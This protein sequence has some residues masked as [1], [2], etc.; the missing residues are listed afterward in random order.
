MKILLIG[1]LVTEIIKYGIW[2][3]GIDGLHLKRRFLGGSLACGYIGL[4]LLGLV[5]E[6]TPIIA[7]NGV[8]VA[9]YVCMLEC[10]R[11]EKL[12]EILKAVFIIIC[13]GEV[14]GNIMQLVLKLGLETFRGIKTSYLANNFIIIAC[15]CTLYIVKRKVSLH[16]SEQANRFYDIMIYFA[17][18]LMGT[19]L[20]LTVSGINYISQY[21]PEKRLE[22]LIKLL[23][24]IS[25]ISIICFIVILLYIFRENKLIKNYLEND[26]LLIM[27]QKSLYDAV[28]AKNKATVDFS[29][30][31][32]G[33]LVCLNEL[34][35]KGD[36]E[37]VGAY[38]ENMTG[39]IELI[40][41]KVYSTENDVIDAVLNYFVAALDE[42]VRI[43]V[44][45]K[46]TGELS[47]EPVELCTITSNIFKNAAEALCKKGNRI[48]YLDVSVMKN[49]GYMMLRVS[50][51]IQESVPAL[52]KRTGLPDTSKEDK[53][54]HGIG[55]RNVK[56]TVEKR[57]GIFNIDIGQEEFAVAI[58][59]PLEI[60]END[61]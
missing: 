60:R 49:R 2:F 54:N 27:T 16:G 20:C 19:S 31:L 6:G 13:A 35:H 40:R 51:S 8:A 12:L 18:V 28:L 39:R 29:H 58:M 17:I 48:R 15:L 32:L 52:D 23:V 36:M 41:N 43:N 38:L 11:E 37:K 45:G 7:W 14:A 61:R 10:R 4:I 59:L 47:I 46:C 44:E 57:G 1:I 3:A 26:K 34:V 21:V 53:E 30:D 9:A 55:L 24:I 50:N 33:H 22:D 56:E 42:E 5:D 25:F